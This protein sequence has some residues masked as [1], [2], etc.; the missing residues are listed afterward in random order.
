MIM[1]FLGRTYVN[2]LL[3]KEAFWAFFLSQNAIFSQVKNPL[4]LLSISF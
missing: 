3:S 4:M 2:I 1:T